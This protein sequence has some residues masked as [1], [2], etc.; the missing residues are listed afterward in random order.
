MSFV[1]LPPASDVL[2]SNSNTGQDHKKP[3]SEDGRVRSYP[4]QRG[5]W[6]TFPFVY[7]ML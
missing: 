1:R 6:T 5:Q 3:I 2:P 7:C 4:H